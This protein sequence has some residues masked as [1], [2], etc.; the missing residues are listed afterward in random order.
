MTTP[1]WYPDP[2]GKDRDHLR[3]WD[4]EK[5]TQYRQPVRAFGATPRPTPTPTASSSRLW[6]TWQL[7]TASTVALLLGVVIG[8]SFSSSDD[9]ADVASGRGPTS[10]T[11]DKETTPSTARATEEEKEPVETTPPATAPPATAPPTTAPG[12]QWVEVA[13]LSGT[14]N[15]QGGTFTLESGKARLRYAF[16]AGEFGGSFFAY[17]VD[18]GDSLD[19]S[20]G[21]PEV[22]CLETCSDATL[23]RKPAGTYYLDVTAANGGWTILVEE[24]R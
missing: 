21:F 17:V 3:W 14:S 19:V 1:G 5:W 16:N 6:K 9:V 24:V 23:L 2:D 12:P 8:G 15:K 22:N 20:G 18:E 10:S 4:G 7:A 11:T 13:T